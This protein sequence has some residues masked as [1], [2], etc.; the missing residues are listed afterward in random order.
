MMVPDIL[1]N[2]DLMLLV[3]IL[4][5]DRELLD[6]FLNEVKVY[7]IDQEEDRLSVLC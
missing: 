3:D 5:P 4:E 7:R 6:H 1:V 2:I